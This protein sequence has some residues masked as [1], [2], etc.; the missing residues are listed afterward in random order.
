MSRRQ[1][2]AGAIIVGVLVLVV[3]VLW[4]VQ[5]RA[6]AQRTGGPGWLR[7]PQP[8]E[9]I[10]EPVTPAER[11]AACRPSH[12]SSVC[13]GFGAGSRMLRKYPGTLGEEPSS[14][15]PSGLNITIAGGY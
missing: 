9:Y 5:R 2:V 7:R 14:L 12:M 6:E 3:V 10:P 13:T 15:V 8:P 1:K 4:C 11:W